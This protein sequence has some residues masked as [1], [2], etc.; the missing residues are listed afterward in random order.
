MNREKIRDL[1]SQMT[2]EV[3]QLYVAPVS[4]EVLRP[5]RELKG[6]EIF[7]NEEER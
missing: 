3:V 5:V 4:F 6:F 2:L 7:L 1:V